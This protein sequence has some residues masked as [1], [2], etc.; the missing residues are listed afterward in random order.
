VQGMCGRHSKDQCATAELGGVERVTEVDAIDACLATH[1]IPVHWA[2]RPLWRQ[3]V[4]YN[5]YTSSLNALVGKFSNS[6]GG[7]CRD[8]GFGI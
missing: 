7:G 3:L 4:Q 5:P 1:P 8:V 2:R 6:G